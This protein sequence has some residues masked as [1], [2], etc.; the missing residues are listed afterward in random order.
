[1]AESERNN[2]VT[3]CGDFYVGTTHV[4]FGNRGPLRRPVP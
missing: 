3:P 4:F 1:M 2:Y